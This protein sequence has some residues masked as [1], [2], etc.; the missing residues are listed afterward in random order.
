MKIYTKTGDSGMTGLFA[1]PRVAKHHPRIQAYGSIDELNA[2]LGVVIAELAQSPPS[3]GGS[4]D[5]WSIQQMAELLRE[6]QSDLFSIG[7][8][9][10][11]PDPQAH[12]MCLLSRDRT[13][14]LEGAIDA[15]EAAL[16]ALQSFILPGGCRESAFLHLARTVCRRA[17]RDVVSLVHEDGVQECGP[18]IEFLNRLSDLLFLL[19]RQANAA[20][21]YQDVTWNRPTMG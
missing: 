10:A 14:E 11:T 9:L 13:G 5:Q 2:L 1:G 8:Q 12:D 21:N 19:A 4:A 20:H 15:L 6:I 7:A 16:P 17:E 18:L 3:E